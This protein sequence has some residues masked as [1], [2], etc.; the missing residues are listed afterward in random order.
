METALLGGPALQNAVN[1]SVVTSD[2]EV[3]LSGSVENTAQAK[4]AFQ[5]AR[6]VEGVKRVQ[7]KLVRASKLDMPAT[8]HQS[9]TIDAPLKGDPIKDNKPP[10]R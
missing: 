2:G 5:V 9:I 6:G 4:R 7:D 3:A 8:P 1:L 10:S